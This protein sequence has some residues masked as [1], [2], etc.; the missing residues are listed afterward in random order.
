M[1]TLTRA[2]VANDINGSIA[3]LGRALNLNWEMGY[4]EGQIIILETEESWSNGGSFTVCNDFSVSYQLF[5]ENEVPCHIVDYTNESEL[6][7]I[8]AEGCNDE[9]ECLIPAGTKL[10]VIQGEQSIDLEEMGYYTIQLEY[11]EEDER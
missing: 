10:R 9:K 7:A 3:N 1:M 6:K 2:S 8:G 4:E 11:V 5:I